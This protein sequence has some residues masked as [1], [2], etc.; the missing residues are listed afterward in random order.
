M[1]DTIDT[2]EAKGRQLE[3]VELLDERFKLRE[4]PDRTAE[5]E[6]AHAKLRELLHGAQQSPKATSD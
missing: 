6:S 4:D 2:D 3:I 5:L 1:D